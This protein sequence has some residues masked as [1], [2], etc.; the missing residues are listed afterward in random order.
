[1]RIGNA[2]RLR[3]ATG[4]APTVTFEEMVRRLVSSQAPDAAAP[5]PGT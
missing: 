4:W 5:R 2:A 3:A 1:V